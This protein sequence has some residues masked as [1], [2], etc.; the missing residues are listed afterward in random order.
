MNKEVK[1]IFS[2]IHGEFANYQTAIASVLSAYRRDLEAA[3]RIQVPPQQ[4]AV[5]EDITQGIRGAKAA[6]CLAVAVYDSANRGQW[7]Q[8]KALADLSIRS[9]EE[10]L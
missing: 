1:R 8:T 3:K 2:D 7:D 5:F 6:D 9:F 10:L 4:C